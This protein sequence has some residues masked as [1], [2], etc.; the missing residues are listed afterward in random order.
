MEWPVLK[1]EKSWSPHGLIHMRPRPIPNI[2][3]ACPRNTH[4]LA[5]DVLYCVQELFA[6]LSLFWKKYSGNGQLSDLPYQ[7][8]PFFGLHISQPNFIMKDNVSLWSAN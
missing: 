4:I 5:L 2:L 6:S 7:I 1:K 3:I 8:P